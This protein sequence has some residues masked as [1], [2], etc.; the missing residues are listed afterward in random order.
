MTSTVTLSTLTT[1]TA[2]PAC[3]RSFTHVARRRARSARRPSSYLLGPTGYVREGESTGDRSAAAGSFSCGGGSGE[4]ELRTAKKIKFFYFFLS[5][6][7][8]PYSATEWMF[9]IQ[10]H[11]RRIAVRF[12]GASCSTT[13]TGLGSRPCRPCS[14]PRIAFASQGWW[15][16][17][18]KQHH[19][20]GE[21][22]YRSNL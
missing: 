9:P 15:K 4:A 22:L 18:H 6:H 16:I 13:R 5:V 2:R 17:V 21:S 12:V 3:I 10:Q 1:T 7:T 19:D 14:H 20:I 8:T 11:E